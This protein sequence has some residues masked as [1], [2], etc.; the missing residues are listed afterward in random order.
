MPGL[1]ALHESYRARGLRV[2]AVSIDRRDADPEVR[3]FLREH[4]I[5]LTVLRDPQERVSRAFRTTGVPETFLIDREGK[6]AARW[7]GQFDPL[8]EEAQA[9]VREVVGE[10]GGPT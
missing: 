8:S 3:E 4:R 6:I 5:D 2:L 9:R 1:Q 10:P 7:I